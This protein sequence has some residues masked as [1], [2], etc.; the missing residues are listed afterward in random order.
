[1][2]KIVSFLKKDKIIYLLL[3]II[4]LVDRVLVLEN[5]NFKYVGSDDLI[6][7]QS[8]TDY[9]RGIF[10]EPYFYGQNYNFM[11]ESFF[12]IPFLKLGVPYNYA[13]PIASSIVSLFPFF[14]FSGVLFKRGYVVESMFFLLIPIM[15]PIEYGMICSNTRGMISGLFFTGFYIFPL[16][17]P[18]KKSSWIITVLS[19]SLGYICNPNSLVFSFPICIYLFLK[20]YKRFSFYW[21]NLLFVIPILLIE[22]FAKRFYVQHTEYIVSW[23]WTLNYSLNL[24]LENFQRLDNFFCYLAP[25]TWSSGWLILFVIL[26]VGVFL[27]KKDWRKG[28]SVVLGV[29]FIFSTLGINKVN[30]YINTVFFSSNRMYLGIPMFL[31]LTFFWGK[32]F[33]TAKDKYFKFAFIII[34]ISTF[35]IKTSLFPVVIKNHTEKTNYGSVGIK[36]IKELTCNCSKLDYI[37]RT[38]NIDLILFTPNWKINVPSLEFYNYGCPLLFKNFPKTMMSVYERRTWVYLEEKSKI[39]KNILIY[40]LEIDSTLIRKQLDYKILSNDPPI[41]IIKNNSMKT[42]ALSKFLNIELKR[43]GY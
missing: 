23:A 22:F 7:W 42:E 40:G 28:L 31:G 9:M 24:A 13:F 34:A 1:M 17:N 43:N 8:A 10:H 2:Q 41:L 38:N 14:L 6:F 26:I 21:I 12:A 39:R 5:F 35:C 37:S 16:L 33:F 20:N 18:G 32:E 11:L 19:L 25:L 3:L 4:V 15:L 36:P 30:D 29:I 27:L